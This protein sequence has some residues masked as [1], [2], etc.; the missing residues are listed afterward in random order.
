MTTLW[1][2]PSA[3]D[4]PFAPPIQ[5]L[6]HLPLPST[7]PWC[8][9]LRM[10]SSEFL[11][12]DK[13]EVWVFILP[14]L[15]LWGPVLASFSYYSSTCQGPSPMVTTLLSAS[16]NCSPFSY[17]QTRICFAIPRMLYCPLSSALNSTDTLVISLS[18]CSQLLWVPHLVS[19]LW[20]MYY[21]FPFIDWKI[22]A[23]TCY[24][25][26]T[27]SKAVQDCTACKH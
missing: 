6:S 16:G 7:A 25:T 10:S 20:I 27:A 13:S 11:Q 3:T 21:C 14:A 18:K 2:G 8:W 12:W 24:V 9:P 5:F 19:G 1:R 23:L 26:C 15:S 22:E 4:F 17:L